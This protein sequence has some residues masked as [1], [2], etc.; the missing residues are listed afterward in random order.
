MNDCCFFCAHDH[1]AITLQLSVDDMVASCNSDS[2]L[3]NSRSTL[4]TLKSYAAAYGLPVTT[5][6]AGPSVMVRFIHMLPGCCLH[7]CCP[8]KALMFMRLEVCQ[9]SSG[10][11]ECYAAVSAATPLATCFNIP[12]PVYPC[13]D[14]RRRL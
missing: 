6:E 9:H 1:I 10:A 5:Y 12:P 4:T 11:P 3:A 2:Q 8:F 7:A 13:C 14:C